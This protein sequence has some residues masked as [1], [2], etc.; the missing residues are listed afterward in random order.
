M[1]EMSGALDERFPG[2][3]EQLLDPEGS[4][5]RWVNVFVEDVTIAWD[6]A[7]TYKLEPDVV[8]RIVSNVA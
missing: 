8:V 4:L 1:R 7:T 3:G 6:G 2:L 5:R